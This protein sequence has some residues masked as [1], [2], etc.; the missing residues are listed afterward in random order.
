MTDR[1]KITQ[2]IKFAQENNQDARIAEHVT[3]SGPLVSTA[4]QA[5]V[6]NLVTP[7][8]FATLITEALAYMYVS[9][10]RDAKFSEKVF[11]VG[12]PE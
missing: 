4:I 7:E 10:Y 11:V 12:E 3:V 5:I 8:G 2:A 9:G 6:S 1:E